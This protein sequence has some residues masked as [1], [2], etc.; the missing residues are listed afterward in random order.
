MLL[1][2]M[3]NSTFMSLL[4][5][6]YYVAA[7]VRSGLTFNSGTENTIKRYRAQLSLGQPRHADL[8]H[9]IILHTCVIMS[10]A[11]QVM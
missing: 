9:D 4:C 8:S 5:V 6:R 10:S 1:A 3:L 2:A 11:M 7:K